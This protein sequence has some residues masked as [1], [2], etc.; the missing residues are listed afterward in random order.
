MFFQFFCFQFQSKK[1]SLIKALT[2]FAT[3]ATVDRNDYTI[4]ISCTTQLKSLLSLSYSFP[5]NTARGVKK[6]WS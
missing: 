5:E 1:P 4:E 2:G 3:Q 6:R